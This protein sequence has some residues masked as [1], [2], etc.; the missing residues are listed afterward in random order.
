MPR[1]NM[2]SL[3]E[4]DFHCSDKNANTTR[5]SNT[6]ADFGSSR[7]IPSARH[8]ARN[9]AW[10]TTTTF[11]SL[12]QFLSK[13]FTLGLLVNVCMSGISHKVWMRCWHWPMGLF[14]ALVT[15][16][17][18]ILNFNTRIWRKPIHDYACC[19][20][21]NFWSCRVNHCKCI[22]V[23]GIHLDGLKCLK[24]AHLDQQIYHTMGSHGSSFVPHVE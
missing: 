1:M 5:D 15:F 4:P 16:L 24:R 18:D 23:M 21:N 17:C 14:V 11:P 6:E 12:V 19:F 9:Q 2:W 20:V 3:R 22:C 13:Y 10:Q 7:S 8:F